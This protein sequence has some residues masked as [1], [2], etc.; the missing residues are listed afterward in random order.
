MNKKQ[1]HCHDCKE[2]IKVIKGKIKNGVGLKYKMGD[3]EYEVF[4]C[5]NC[6][7]KD[8][9]LHNFQPTEVYSRVCGYLRPVS[10]WN[11]GKIQE[12]KEK[13]YYKLNENENTKKK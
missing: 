2:S 6:Y 11:P 10:Q 13:K 3:K 4:K 9:A 7:D 8:K 12:H 1:Y 5:Q